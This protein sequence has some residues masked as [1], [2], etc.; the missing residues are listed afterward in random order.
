MVTTSLIV[1]VVIAWGLAVWS[2]CHRWQGQERRIALGA[3]FAF[4]LISCGKV[5]VEDLE[6]PEALAVLTFLGLVAIVVVRSKVELT[7]FGDKEPP[8]GWDET[9]EKLEAWLV[10]IGAAAILLVIAGL[11]FI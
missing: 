7:L 10:P 2:A 1:S 11:L 8:E 6:L 9:D 4:V 3:M 5:A